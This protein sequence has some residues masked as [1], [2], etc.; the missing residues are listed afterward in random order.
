MF[1]KVFR[2]KIMSFSGTDNRS[3]RDPENLDGSGPVDSRKAAE[4]DRLAEA[5]RANL[6]R[7][8]AQKRN[9]GKQAEAGATKSGAVQSGDATKQS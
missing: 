2:K 6:G 1:C 4:R 3:S 8:K 9:R 5:L 7:R